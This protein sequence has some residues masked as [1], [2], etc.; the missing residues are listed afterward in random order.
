MTAGR[1]F[2]AT[3]TAG[4]RVRL[5]AVLA[6][7]AAGLTVAVLQTT[8]RWQG[9]R[10][11]YLLLG[12]INAFLASLATWFFHIRWRLLGDPFDRH[13]KN[14]FLPIACHFLLMLV[15]EAVIAS[16]DLAEAFVGFSWV[17]SQTLAAA[18]LL[19]T[20]RGGREHGSGLRA[21]RTTGAVGFAVAVWAVFDYLRKHELVR[22]IGPLEA[23]LATVFLVA[24]V[25]PMIGG[26]EQRQPREVWLGAAFLLT[27][28]AHID[29]S[30][31]REPYDSPFM[32]GYVLIAFS[33]ATPT[34]GAV[35]ENVTLLESQ[36][37][38]SVRLKR[39]RQR[40]EIL[41][42]SLPVLVMSVDRDRNIRYANRA[43]SSL[44]AV[45]Q[46]M[47]DTDHGTTWLDRIHA[48]HRPQIYSA[49][50]SVLEGG[51]GSWEG[52][53]RGEDSSGNVHWL[54]TQMQPIVDPVVNETLIQIV[55]IDVTDLHLAR[56]AAEARQTRLAFLSNF[57]QTMAGEVEEQRILDHFLEMGRGLLP[58]QSLLLYRPISGGSGLKLVTGAG[59][60]VEAF[61]EDRFRPIVAGD[62]PCWTAYH[63]RTPQTVSA[64]SA[65]PREL[66]DW[67]ATN[68]DIRNLSYLPLMA[69]G[70]SAGV[71]LATSNTGLDLS[72][73]DV[74][75][76][77]QV[78]FLIGGAVS[79]SQLVRELDEQRAVAFEASR[80]KSEFLANTS[81][82][83]R[84]PLTAILGFLRL[85][86]DGAVKDPE[87]QREF[88]SIAHESAENLLNIINDVLDLAKIEAGRLEV[89][90]APVPARTVLDDVQAL[91]KHQMKSKGLKFRTE[92][93]DKKLVIWADPD[94]TSQVLTNLLS[95]AMKFTD[96][97]GSIT[98][99]CSGADGQIAFAVVDT[100]IG[101]A[102]E[103][104]EKTFSSFY[105]VDGSTTRQ[106][107][108][109]GL[110]LTIS[111]RLAE[112]MG[113]SLE[114]D[115]EGAGHGTTAR[116]TL[117]EF[118]A[119]HDGTNP[120][121]RVP[122]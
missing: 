19:F 115:S 79:L 92:G 32:W 2:V 50:P 39:L 40:M 30:W 83:L 23:G 97:G 82:E 112:L 61:E 99:R 20:F 38:L 106:R 44:F 98:V 1:V 78:G 119:E 104:L 96:R 15:L 86:M 77:T 35:F 62:H 57:A 13:V 80:L 95:N 51:R 105:Q 33:L 122:T 22:G 67:L 107:G 14:V 31:S 8:V 55:A 90:F 53:V 21:M 16:K 29:L 69:A 43:A 76:L 110:G 63:L 108:G 36:T 116:L 47:G 25:V 111:R 85:I 60:G 71:L 37:A 11:E 26:R 52:L 6:A 4:P 12:G 64:S 109:T 72:I 91:F 7:V 68:H 56:R 87:K 102:R 34:V 73:D 66:A 48:A 114:L 24:A 101:I 121:I 117:K 18:I 49:I 28:I 94:R 113:G 46:V 58:L 10:I 59:P 75:L 88:L 70:R 42:D 100:G 3:E 17:V 45:P 54:N 120:E 5:L 118:S 89:H 9:D 103:E 27:A 41:L 74:D 84:T 65:L 81:H 93:G